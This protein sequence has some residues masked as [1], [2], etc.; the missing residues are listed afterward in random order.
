[1]SIHIIIDGYNL[2]RQSN[3]F[4]P[5]DRRDMQLGRET[6]IE[7]LAAY[8]RIKGHKITVVF[9]GAQAPSFF[10]SRN[11]IK[12]IKVMF[13]RNDE[14]ADTVIKRMAAREKAKVLVV[15]SDL[16]VINFAASAGCAT[17]SSLQF[18]EKIAM[19]TYMDANGIGRENEG[20]WVPTTKKKGP[21]R[22]LSKKKRQSKIKIQKL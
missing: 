17:I 2:I 19:A 14:S 5:I 3:F 7:T 9:D 21:R 4:S 15:S 13:S 12:G 11:Q 18:E 6:L 10:Q 1:M 16:D 20:G 22:R 8:K